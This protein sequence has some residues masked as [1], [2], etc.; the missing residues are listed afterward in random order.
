M[1]F[2]VRARRRKLLNF[3]Q[4]GKIFVQ[5][6]SSMAENWHCFTK[7][8]RSAFYRRQIVFRMRRRQVFSRERKKMKKTRNSSLVKLSLTIR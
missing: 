8:S 6:P 4:M 2:D 7:P 3:N 5:M 1:I